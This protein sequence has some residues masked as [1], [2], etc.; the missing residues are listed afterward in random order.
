MDR[1]T[2]SLVIHLGAEL[3]WDDIWRDSISST[4]SNSSLGQRK[5]LPTTIGQPK[6]PG[7]RQ[8]MRAILHLHGLSAKTQS[9]Q[10]GISGQ[11][12]EGSSLG[13]EDKDGFVDGWALG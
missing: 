11:N 12:L 13:I 1:W 6:K 2:D 3:G 4:G 8:E 7:A 5:G 9:Q 10:Q